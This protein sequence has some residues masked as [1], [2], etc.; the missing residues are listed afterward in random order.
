MRS[1]EISVNNIDKLL[2]TRM[3][4]EHG[5]AVDMIGPLP[6]GSPI[7]KLDPRDTCILWQQSYNCNTVSL[8]GV[9]LTAENFG[10]LPCPKKQNQQCIALA[11][12]SSNMDHHENGEK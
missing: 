9:P 10:L 11:C 6:Y 3:L 1:R 5:R 12:H 7:I 2:A 8:I 4:G